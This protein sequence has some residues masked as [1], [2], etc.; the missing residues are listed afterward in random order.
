[1]I[2]KLTL[3]LAAVLPALVLAA[4]K[5]ATDPKAAPATPPPAAAPAAGD[6]VAADP[7][8]LQV[9]PLEG[10]AKAAEGGKTAVA[11]PDTY[12][13]RPGDTLWDLSGRFL[14]NPWYWPKVWSYN[15]DISNPHWISPGN[16]L[17]FFP[18]GE[19][20]AVEV[21]PVTPDEPV[22][23]EETPEPR[24]LEDLSRADMKAPPSDVERDVVSVSRPFGYTQPRNAAARHDAFVTARELDES[25]TIKASFEEKEMLSFKD[26]AYVAFRK[27]APVKVGET[28]TIFRTLRQVNHPV[29]NDALGFETVILGK[30]KVVAVDKTAASVV[31]T[32]SYDVIERGDRLGPW[33]ESDA[34]RIV[35]PKPNAK[36]LKGY[37]VG[38]PQEFVTQ[39]AQQQVVFLDR[40]KA[41]GVE[42][43][44][45]FTVVRSGD[46]SGLSVDAM[47]WDDTLPIEDVGTLL[48]VDVK[49]HSST[50]L[51]TRSLVELRSG[52]RVE[53]RVADASN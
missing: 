22:A 18:S 16:T 10:G 12:T 44:N 38:A 11:P 41:E 50:A 14:N 40:G 17:R 29:T 7:G 23:E 24:E 4:D 15:P 25:G 36:K 34:Y 19:E 31:I 3:A 52:D 37:I 21:V 32:A 46:P 39:H 6:E 1:M 20:G 35:K 13:I 43:G 2:R 9:A 42:E 30:A 45:R 33:V 51:V 27:P 26:G 53:M 47:R 8:A 48:V 5:P 49:D 28:Y